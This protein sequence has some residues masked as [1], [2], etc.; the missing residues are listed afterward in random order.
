LNPLLQDVDEYKG[1]LLKP[2]LQCIFDR[3]EDIYIL[4]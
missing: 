2:P 1:V 4:R 3:G